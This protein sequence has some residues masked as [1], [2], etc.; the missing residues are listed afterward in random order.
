MKNIPRCLAPLALAAAVATPADAAKLAAPSLATYGQPVQVEL[1]ETVVYLPA[2][3]FTR[4]GSTIIIDYEYAPNAFLTRPDFGTALLTLG[5]LVP[6]NYRIEAR[7]HHMDNPAA[8][9]QVLTQSLAVAPPDNWGIYLIPKAPQA[10]AATDVM[11]R[12]AAYFDPASMR[13]TAN[14]NTIR[15]DFD[16]RGD[17]PVGISTPPEMTSFA[18]VRLPPLAPGHYTVEGWGRDKSSGA[19]AQRYFS[20]AFM[21]ASAVPV[22]EYYAASLDHY[23]MTAAPDETEALDASRSWQRTGQTFKAWLRPSDA[24]PNAKPVCR[25]Y[26]T[27][28]NS[29]FYTGDAGECEQI[30]AL[31]AEQRAA[32]QARGAPFR[33]WAF[34]NIAFYAL[35]PVN[36]QCP[37]DTTPVY[38]AYNDRAPQN[39]TNHRFTAD[40]RQHD[41]M[42]MTW[43]DE[44]VAFCSPP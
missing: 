43:L 34:E 41:A 38:R 30:K 15:V 11:I 4:M 26:A 8:P 31:E 5:E 7:L 27:G 28:P 9:A 10:F 25:F 1:R 37:P 19:A 14:G 44:G 20:Q 2:T 21:V 33:G 3:R 24:P 42:R 40:P 36:G 16:Y 22:V 18:A 35:L 6:G 17:A 32:A 12:S 29:H 39:D 13:V 23:F